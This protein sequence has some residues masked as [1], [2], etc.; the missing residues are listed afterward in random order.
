MLMVL[1]LCAAHFYFIRLT[2]L[3][4]QCIRI[5]FVAVG[6]F[7]SCC[8]FALFSVVSVVIMH[9]IIAFTICRA[10]YTNLTRT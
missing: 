2:L 8:T 7:S 3:N 1:C 9:C 4:M 6:N 5:H 10:H